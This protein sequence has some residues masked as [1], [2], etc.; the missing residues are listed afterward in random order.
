MLVPKIVTLSG[1]VT[2]VMQYLL[3]LRIY[4][5]H[6]FLTIYSSLHGFIWNQHHDQLP[7]GLSAQL[8]ERCTSIAEV[9]GLNPVQAWIF[10]RPYFH[11]CPSRAHYCKDHF[12]SLQVLTLHCIVKLRSIF[13][14]CI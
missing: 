11:Y 4:E 1:R 12:H 8:V 7:V 14:N 2:D 5:S 10:F 9:M 6:I 13:D 3:W